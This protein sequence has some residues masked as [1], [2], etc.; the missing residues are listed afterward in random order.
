MDLEKALR[1]LA[2]PREIGAHPEDGEPIEAGI[3]RYGPYVKHGRI[4]ANLKD[5]DEVFT[6]GMNRAVELLAQKA[7]GRR[8]AARTAPKALKELGE[9]PDGGPIQVLDGRYGPYVKWGK[10]NATIP[11]GTSPEDLNIDMALELIAEKSTK[12][13][14]KAAPRK[15]SSAAAKAAE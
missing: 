12:K 13:G 11:K 4:Y 8:G 10:V 15:K 6:V 7:A 3:G 2:L 5:P 14:K 1:L 9:H